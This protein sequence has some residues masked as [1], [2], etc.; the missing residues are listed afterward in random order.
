MTGDSS[1][2]DDPPRW[3]DPADAG[4]P[5]DPDDQHAMEVSLTMGDP[6]SEDDPPRAAASP[7]AG[8][9]RPAAR[10]AGA[11]APGA[12]AAGKEGP[13]GRDEGAS[14]GQGN[15][16]QRK[17]IDQKR[18]YVLLTVGDSSCPL[19]LSDE[20]GLAEHEAGLADGSVRA[21]R[22]RRVRGAVFIGDPGPGFRKPG[23]GGVNAT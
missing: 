14:Q 15:A 3:D 17:F 4:N 6:P 22:I 19:T 12:E 10:A 21:L 5:S 2:A 1:G 18:L 8:D 11:L 20:Q 9:P 13:D 23:P 7:L 16:G